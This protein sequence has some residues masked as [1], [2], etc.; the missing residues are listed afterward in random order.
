MRPIDADA[1][2]GNLKE[3]EFQCR[4]ML[5]SGSEL[6]VEALQ[7]F[8]NM[9]D[10]APTIAPPPNAPLT[11]E[12]LRGMDGRPVWVVGLSSINDFL[13]HWDICNLGGDSPLFP[14]CG[15]DP[16]INLYGITWKVYRR[17]PEEGTNAAT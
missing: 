16:D 8:I 14:Y 1:L 15:E 7:V 10:S 17:K 13:G 11:M 3:L 4:K 2:K 6:Y 9:I 5:W 12:E